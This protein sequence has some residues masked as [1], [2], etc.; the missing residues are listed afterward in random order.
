MARR[1]ILVLG[2]LLFLTA[3]GVYYII[4]D[5]LRATGDSNTFEPL[6]ELIYPDD[7]NRPGEPLV[8]TS[9]DKMG[10]LQAIFKLPDYERRS[11]GSY[12]LKNPEVTLFQDDV[13]QLSII[14]DEGIVYA[15][16]LADTANVRRGV[17]TGN[18]QLVYYRTAS[19]DGEDRPED[20]IRFFTERIEFDNDEL[21]ITSDEHVTVFSPEADILG[22]G[23]VIL[24]NDNPR[25]LRLLRIEQGEYLAIKR[26]PKNFDS[27]LREDSEQGDATD[28]PAEAGDEDDQAQPL[29]DD[30]RIAELDASQVFQAPGEAI[31]TLNELLQPTSR[32]A[33]QPARTKLPPQPNVYRATF[34][35]SV[36]L[37]GQVQLRDAERLILVFNWAESRGFRRPASPQP[38]SSPASQPGGQDDQDEKKPQQMQQLEEPI[39]ITWTGPLVIEPIGHTDDPSEQRVRLAAE[40]PNLELSD[41]RMRASLGRLL[42]FHPEQIAQLSGADSELVRVETVNGEEISCQQMRFDANRSLAYFA[43]AGRIIAEADGRFDLASRMQ[44]VK[45]PATQP[46]GRNEIVW[47]D[48]VISRFASVETS[49]ANGLKTTQTILTE[50]IFRG[51]VSLQDAN[52]SIRGDKFHLWTGHSLGDQFP[53]KAVMSGNVSTRQDGA[54]IQADLATIHFEQRTTLDANGQAV[55]ET[56]ANSIVFEGNVRVTLRDGNQ[57]T[58]ATGEKIVIDAAEEIARLYGSPARVVQGDRKISGAEIYLDGKTR[59]VR[60]EGAGQMSFVTDRDLDGAKR[61]KPMPMEIS[62]QSRMSFDGKGKVATFTGPVKLTTAESTIRCTDEMR[63]TFRQVEGQPAE[64]ATAGGAFEMGGLGKMQLATVLAVKNVVVS[65]SEVDAEGHLLRRFQLNT[66]HLIYDD[67]T[68]HIGIYQP[69]ELL[70]EDYH[71]PKPKSLRS[72][73]LSMSSGISRPSQTFFSWNKQMQL[74]LDTYEIYMKGDVAMV[75]HSG[76]NVTRPRDV[77]LLPWPALS[78][79]RTSKL[80]C[81]EFRARFL[82]PTDAAGKPSSASLLDTGAVVGDIDLFSATGAAGTLVLVDGDWELRGARLKYQRDAGR[83]FLWGFAEGEEVRMAEVSHASQAKPTISAKFECTFDG[84]HIRSV[85]TARLI[86]GSTR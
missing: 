60:V 25:Q 37:D 47:N 9:R 82:P 57:I 56:D 70:V 15:E 65:S 86:G 40:G 29:S 85:K 64:A 46:A 30:D 38:T 69:G 24:W 73:A 26:A 34:N 4:A 58:L 3:F 55:V 63:A 35:D 78:E 16:E 44:G 68:G 61:A 51:E 14:G 36:R 20:Q 77:K 54:L 66:D 42:Y 52:Q 7:G 80:A 50:A 76:A 83:A 81:D 11:D 1:L 17:L 43:G 10:R 48:S 22:K 62:W 53:T 18:V 74:M 8:F 49:D 31:K 12:Y 33:S 71:L 28:K 2:I 75:H 19:P 27:Q 39:I 67:E 84:Q 5:S 6:D 45:T 72:G 79:G 32:P 21:R 41:E 59:S 23:L 13:P